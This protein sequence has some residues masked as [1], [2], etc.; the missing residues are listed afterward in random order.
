MANYTTSIELFQDKLHKQTNTHT[1]NTIHNNNN[2]NNNNNNMKNNKKCFR[3]NA[4]I[5]GLGEPQI[6]SGCFREKKMSCA[7]RELNQG[8]SVASTCNALRRPS[9]HLR[10]V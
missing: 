2:N 10:I 9:K 3:T 4:Q 7:C 1:N 5:R 8:P 6:P